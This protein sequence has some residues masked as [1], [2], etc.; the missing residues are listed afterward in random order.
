MTLSREQ[1]ERVTRIERNLYEVMPG[2]EQPGYVSLRDG[3]EVKAWGDVESTQHYEFCHLIAW[4][5]V[6]ND[7]RVHV[8][9]LD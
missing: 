7:T 6:S 1:L 4:L 5:I 2:A 8:D 9:A 3:S